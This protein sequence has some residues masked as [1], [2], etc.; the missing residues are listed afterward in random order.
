MKPLTLAAWALL[1]MGTP[2]RAGMVLFDPP[3][4]TIT[5][6]TQSVSFATHAVPEMLT[7]FDTVNVIFGSLEG[8]GFS[9]RYDPTFA[10]CLCWLP[11]PA[12]QGV[13]DLLTGGI[14]TDIGLG[15]NR[16]PP[17]YPPWTSATLGILSIDTS[18]LVAGDVRQIVVSPELES[19]VLMG[20]TPP[21]ASLLASGMNFE[22]LRGA[23][24]ITVVPEPATALILLIL[25]GIGLASR[26][27]VGP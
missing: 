2:S 5:P 7:S 19:Q 13:Y 21:F 1:V 10:A 14:G 15:G 24:T 18:G 23:V 16:F 25:G 26:R 22:P 6:G 8:L 12:E 4:I 27:G 11:P 20:N 3:A 17:A 9:F